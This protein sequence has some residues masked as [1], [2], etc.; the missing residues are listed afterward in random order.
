VVTGLDDYGRG[1]DVIFGEAGDDRL[2]GG[3]G[4]DWLDGGVG[5]D[6]LV[7]GAGDDVLIGGEGADIFVMRSAFGVD[8]IMDF[9][10]EDMLHVTNNVNGIGPLTTEALAARL[11]DLGGDAWLDLGG[12]RGNGVLFLGVEADVLAGLFETNVVFI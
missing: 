9:T 7:G 2:H 3:R 12:E 4:D 6:T 5:D 1:D 8:T 11:E 10:A